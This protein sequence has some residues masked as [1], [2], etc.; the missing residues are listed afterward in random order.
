MLFSVEFTPFF[1][2]LP[3]LNDWQRQFIIKT[4]LL[5][6]N[7]QTKRSHKGEDKEDDENSAPYF[8][9]NKLPRIFAADKD[10]FLRLLL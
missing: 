10:I 2:L 4:M 3:E 1:L 6:E 9:K 5:A 8:E 7:L